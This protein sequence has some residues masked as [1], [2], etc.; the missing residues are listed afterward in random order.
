MGKS[1][2][3]NVNE[4]LENQAQ[5]FQTVN[6]GLSHHEQSNNRLKLYTVVA[7]AAQ[8]VN[9]VDFTRNHVF[10]FVGGTAPV[11]V[12]FPHLL[13]TV[14]PTNRIVSVINGGTDNLLLRTTPLAGITLAAEASATIHI[15]STTVRLV[16]GSGASGGS[17][18]GTFSIGI[19]NPGLAAANAE[20]L[21]YI[22][23]DPVDFQDNFAGSR[24][25]IG[26]NATAAM[27]FAVKRNGT[28]IGTVTIN[29]AGVYTFSTTGT[30][31]ES[32][33][34]GD[35]LTVHTPVAQDAT[36]ADFAINFKGTKV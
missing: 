26:V 6:D 21:R 36:G 24:G 16:S 8:T 11:T 14:V 20:Q 13:N 12:N 27:A 17:S 22:F 30:G 3:L 10:R 15:E 5:A 23:I 18:G 33:A 34:S 25:S 7:N 4:L 2:L 31:T 32:F 29:P 19:F 1:L 9:E 28:S 35:V